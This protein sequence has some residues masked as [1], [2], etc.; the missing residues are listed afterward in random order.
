MVAYFTATRL[1]A[2]L[3]IKTAPGGAVVREVPMA[4][5]REARAYCKANGLTPWNF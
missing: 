2:F 5:K 4:G 3:T 1:R